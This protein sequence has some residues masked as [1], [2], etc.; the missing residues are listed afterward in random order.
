MFIANDFQPYD[1]EKKMNNII[2]AFYAHDL[3]QLMA[4]EQ[5]LEA[6]Y[7][8]N[9]EENP[10]LKSYILSARLAISQMKHESPLPKDTDN[11]FR[12]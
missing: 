5:E 2:D 8:N 4:E 11:L 3:E 12:L 9:Q 1:S 10:I 6:E 7:I